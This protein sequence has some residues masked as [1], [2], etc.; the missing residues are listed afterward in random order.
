MARKRKSGDGTVRL[1]K[2]ARWEGRVVIGYDDMGTPDYSYD[3]VFILADSNDTTDHNA[4][5]YTVVNAQR[6]FSCF[7]FYSLQGLEGHQ[8]DYCFIAPRLEG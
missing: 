1:R 7:S 5:G 8:A 2:D 6:L 3:D 4:D